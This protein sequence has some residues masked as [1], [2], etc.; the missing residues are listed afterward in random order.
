[1]GLTGLVTV[2]D[3]VPLLFPQVVAV[4]AGVSVTP[5]DDATDMLAVA[6]HPLLFTVTVYVPDARPLTE[7]VVPALPLQ[8]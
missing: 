8:L 6:L 7:A 5:V 4:E 1:V 3:A 2:T